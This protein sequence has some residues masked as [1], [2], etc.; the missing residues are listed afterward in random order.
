MSES[1]PESTV[2]KWCKMRDAYDLDPSKLNPYRE[3]DRCA[4]FLSLPISPLPNQLLAV[5][6]DKLRLQLLEEESRELADSGLPSKISSGAF[7]HKALKIENHWYVEQ[8]VYS[9]LPQDYS[10]LT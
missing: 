4:C 3:V 8:V 5:T 6:L 2:D 7:F 9:I 1:L 10:N